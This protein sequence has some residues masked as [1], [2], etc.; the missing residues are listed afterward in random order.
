MTVTIIKKTKKQESSN[1]YTIGH[2]NRSIEDFMLLLHKHDIKTLVDVRSKP[3]S[4]YN[5]NFNRDMLAKSLM[6]AGIKYLWAGKYLGGF[7]S[8]GVD[9]KNF[10]VKINKVIAL[11]EESTTVMMCSEGQPEKCHRA[12]RLTRWIHANTM[13]TLNHIVTKGLLKSQEFESQHK[14]FWDKKEY[15]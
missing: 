12:Y 5:P 1:L 2:S 10:L 11:S 8:G 3:Y 4:R 9:D 7:F 6:E 13:M 14:S 15:I